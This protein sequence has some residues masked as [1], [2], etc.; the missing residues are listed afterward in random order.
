MK[1]I[2]KKLILNQLN[3]PSQ[4]YKASVY[5]RLNFA[6]LDLHVYVNNIYQKIKLLFTFRLQVETHKL[7]SI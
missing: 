1:I 3:V 2:L 5:G 7:N 4:H 6:I